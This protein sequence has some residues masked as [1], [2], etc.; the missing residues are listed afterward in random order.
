MQQKDTGP[1][2]P[3][4]RYEIDELF[5]QRKAEMHAAAVS[6]GGGIAKYTDCYTGQ[7]LRGGDAYDYEHI[8]SAEE[9]FMQYRD[10][11]TNDQIAVLVNCPANIGVTLRTINQSKGKRKL[12]EWLT[13]EV[14]QRFG[15]NQSLA[16]QAAKKADEGIGGMFR[17]F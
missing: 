12:E 17:R 4:W 3:Y 6:R 14:I 10:R 9:V 8:R 11:L 5:K 15:I 2:R 16:L 7:Q 13:Q 1:N